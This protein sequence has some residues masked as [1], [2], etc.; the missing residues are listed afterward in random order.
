LISAKGQVNARTEVPF[1]IGT[2]ISKMMILAMNTV[3]SGTRFPGEH[4]TLP[5]LRWMGSMDVKY[6]VALEPAAAHDTL[7][8]S[9]LMAAGIL[10]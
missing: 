3:A 2:W 1:V 8:S 5:M 10:S 7:F 6:K 9:M 4:R